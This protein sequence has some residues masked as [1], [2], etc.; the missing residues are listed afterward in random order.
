MPSVVVFL[1][2]GQRHALAVGVVER[3][4]RAVHVAPLPRAP[5]IVTGAIEVRGR[6]VPVLDIRARLRLPSRPISLSDGLLIARA[7]ER[8]V[9]MVVDAVLGTEDIDACDVTAPEA[10]L[11]RL[12]GVTGLAAT[13]TGLIIIQDLDRFLSLDEA[14]ALDDAL[15]G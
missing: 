10:V 14:C 3:V 2:D 5:R 15:A 11:P 1:L 13:G 7:G 6:I 12:E 9:A 4:T 8:S